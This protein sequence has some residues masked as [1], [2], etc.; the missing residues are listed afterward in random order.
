M[1]YAADSAGWVG[2]VY[3]YLLLFLQ[4]AW[5]RIWGG[6]FPIWKRFSKLFTLLLAGEAFL[7][8]TKIL[9]LHKK[10]NDLWV[11]SRITNTEPQCQK[12]SSE[13]LFPFYNYTF[14]WETGGERRKTLP[15]LLQYAPLG[16]FTL[17]PGG[18]TGTMDCWA[19]L[20]ARKAHQASWNSRP[21]TSPHGTLL[22]EMHAFPL[23]CFRYISHQ[24]Q[25]S[26]YHS[27]S[28]YFKENLF[29]EKLLLEFWRQSNSCPVLVRSR[30]VGL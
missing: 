2:I 24:G 5:W 15:V 13:F 4:I 6:S 21:L 20:W 9:R 1:P 26:L 18:C 16:A 25:R 23:L 28:N 22:P 10:W 11:L 3:P 17:G 8:F 14:S 7:V 30:G 29:P 12:N 27:N 19:Q